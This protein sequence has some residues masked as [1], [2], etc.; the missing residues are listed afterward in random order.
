MY[1]VKDNKKIKERIIE[2]SIKHQVLSSQT[3]FICVQKSIKDNEYQEFK[4][5]GNLKIKFGEKR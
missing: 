5:I 2:E 3:A 4:D 1:F